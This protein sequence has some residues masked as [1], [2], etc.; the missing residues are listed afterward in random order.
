MTKS[1]YLDTS[2]IFGRAGG[3]EP[4]RR[5]LK[6][7]TMPGAHA[8][9]TQ[10][11]REWN[12]IVLEG[13]AAFR[14]ALATARDWSDVV[15]KLRK[16]FGGTPS[17]N[18]QVQHWITNSETTNLEVAEKR[19]EDFLRIRTRM[20]FKSGIET[21]RDATEC[22]VAKRSL[23][24]TGKSQKP[25]KYQATCKKGESICVQ[26]AFLRE[27]IERAK[28]AA[29]ALE[30]SDDEQ[31]QRMGKNSAE[32]LK[33][34]ENGNDEGTK[35][36]ACHGK[37]QIGGD[38]LIA[39]ECAEDEVLLATDASFIHICP[40]ISREYERVTIPAEP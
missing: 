23:E 25:W 13:T 30:S 19:A 12:R 8:T 1:Y 27:E 4:L 39:L 29:A 28:A 31:H 26:P 10:V 40:A 16:G 36:S 14:N 22:G 18:W 20:L 33:A 6:A 32:A 38:L 37:N 9:S 7:K 3:E 35:G 21:I 24:E 2:A 34:L 15:A 17:R 5:I 11:L